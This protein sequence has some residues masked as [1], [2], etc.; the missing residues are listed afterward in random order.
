MIDKSHLLR[1]L[2]ESLAEELRRFTDSQTAA[3]EGAIHEET[4][5]E[6]PKDTRAIEAQYLARG[7]AERVESVRETVAFLARL[8]PQAFGAD[9][10][11]GLTALVALDVE[12][13]ANGGGGE[14]L[15]FLL[16]VMGGETLEVDGVAVR[17]L[18][19]ESPLGRALMGRRTDD[20]VELELPGR[21]LRGVVAS[22]S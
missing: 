12:G 18:T 7:L 16:P 3:H 11:V 5:Q 17:T 8:E 4:R 22:V 14:A 13:A 10:P 15:Y 6:D 9:D 20:E 19:P 2:R 1:L 21:A